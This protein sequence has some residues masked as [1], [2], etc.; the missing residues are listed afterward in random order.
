MLSSWCGCNSFLKSLMLTYRLI[1][2]TVSSV[3]G[4]GIF[5]VGENVQSFSQRNDPYIVSKFPISQS[6]ARRH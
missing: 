1:Q 6:V 3:K 5:T 2:A 4:L